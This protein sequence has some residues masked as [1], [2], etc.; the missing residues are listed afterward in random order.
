M[1]EDPSASPGDAGPPGGGASA[2]E[3]RAQ[4]PGGPGGSSPPPRAGGLSTPVAALGRQAEARN[5]AKALVTVLQRDLYGAF[6]FNSDEG[7]AIMKA[8]NALGPVFG[9]G[10]K[11]DESKNAAM[12][13]LRQKAMQQQGM[14]GQAGG[15]G[16]QP[17]RGPIPSM[18]GAGQMGQ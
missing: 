18:A 13:A 4:Q 8:L 16:P 9:G 11:E 1:A 6:E 7:K 14:G 17:N 5:K 15:Q 12:M 3:A 10:G 2:P